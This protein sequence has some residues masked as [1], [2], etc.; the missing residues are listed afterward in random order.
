MARDLVRSGELRRLIRDEGLRGQTSNPTMFEKAI[1][2][3]T[4]YDPSILQLA[5]RTKD[6]RAI[7]E[8]LAE[9]DVRDA[10]DIFRPLYDRTDGRDGFVSIEVSPD[11]A[12]DRSATIDES[13]RLWTAVNRPNLMVKVP[14]TDECVPAVEE[15]L[16]E[17]INVNITLLFSVTHHERVMNA[18]LVAL[19][20]RAAEG[21]PI[22]RIASVASFFV[23]RVDTFVDGLLKERAAFAAPS[24]ADALLAL[25]GTIGVA[26]ARRAYHRFRA[27]FDGAR[28]AG[29]LPRGARPQRPLWASTG[30]KNPAYSDVLYVSS[31]IGPDSVNSMP[32]A[33]LRAFEDH[34]VV[35]RTIDRDPDDARRRLDELCA[36]GFDYD[37]I[38]MK[39]EQEGIAAFAKSQRASI[40]AIESKL[41]F[42]RS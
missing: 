14:G 32:L 19:E 40:K 24:D 2:S 35:E 11:L 31:L 34:G 21:R 39:L 4:S 36:L 3:G 6:P 18:Y 17:G 23:S 13:R 26:N 25:V 42:S 12:R 28:F 22:D 20:R 15:L 37:A 29:L 8:G 7:L 1:A 27:M 30:T 33:T 41:R 10:C 38:T 9:E 16:Y 5:H